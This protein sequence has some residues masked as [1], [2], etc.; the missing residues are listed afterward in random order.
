MKDIHKGNYCQNCGKPSHC[1]VSL[2]DELQNYDEPPTTLKICNQC[3][4]GNCINIEDTK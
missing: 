2:Y 3:R 4:C 1:G